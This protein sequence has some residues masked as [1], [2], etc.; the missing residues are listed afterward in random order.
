MLWSV[1]CSGL[2]LQTTETLWHWQY[3]CGTR[4]Q[5][6]NTA[7]EG[8]RRQRLL[9]VP[10]PHLIFLIYPLFNILL[11]FL[12]SSLVPAMH[13]FGYLQSVK[14]NSYYFHWQP[15][16]W[17][18]LAIYLILWQEERSQTSFRQQTYFFPT[19]LFFFFFFSSWTFSTLSQLNINI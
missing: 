8:L 18:V 3:L 15:E 11:P 9:S 2:M 6:G 7:G 12:S 16:K 13:R 5:S 1:T 4:T 19:E 14:P 17:M 10:Q